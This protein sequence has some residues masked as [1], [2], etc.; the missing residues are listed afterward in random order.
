MQVT[1]DDLSSVKKNLHIEIPEED[2]ARELDEAY[3]SL[4]KTAKVKGF[5]P[6][7]TPRAVLERRFHKDVNADVGSKLIQE[8]LVKAIEENELNV[9]GR[10]HIDP[11][12]LPGKGPYKYTA[13]VEI[14][15]EIEDVDFSG[16]SLKKAL[17]RVTDE[18]IDAQ[19]K[20][21]QQ[22]MAKLEPLPEDRPAAEE[23]FVLIDYEGFQDGKP[24]PE[25]QK[26]ENYS[27]KIGK[28]VI[29][30]EFDAQLIGMEKGVEREFSVS[31]PDD[32]FNQTLAGK[33]VAF[34]VHLRDIRKEILPALDD[35]FAKSVGPFENLE[36]LRK[37][38][39]DNLMNGYEKR[40]EQELNEQIFSALLEKTDFEVPEAL[41]E[42]ELDH[43]VRDAER[44]FQ[45]H[46]MD[47]EKIG[48]TPETM[49]ERYRET[50]EKQV[51]RHL[52]LSKIMQ[53]EKLALSE[54]DLEAGF[55]EMAGQINRPVEEIKG[56]YRQDKEQLEFFKHTLL[57]KSAIKL[58]IEAASVE[59]TEAELDQGGPSEQT[60]DGS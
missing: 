4:R 31:F 8:S 15:P 43:I 57:E 10:P 54:D 13:T 41:L 45:Y 44:S 25:L 60:Q 47:P 22:N 26:T 50:A 23:D 35:A 14:N 6:G 1:I 56:F 3:N 48:L 7:K 55:Q 20:L 49:R 34:K 59:E 38:I 32:Y 28:A 16:L 17:Y 52:I 21:I 42:Y 33:T 18:E 5:R 37:E 58:I 29:S 36:A 2:V 40:S 27:L 51:R 24:M 53:Q 9:V 30:K 12:E 19:L 46:N 11:P 39:A